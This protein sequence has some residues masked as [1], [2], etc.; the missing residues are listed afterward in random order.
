[1]TGNNLPEIGNNF[2]Q[3]R[4][5]TRPYL[6][7]ALWLARFATEAVAF[8]ALISIIGLGLIAFGG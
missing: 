3:D 5:M 1:M 2:P 6:R 7:R 8:A 4:R